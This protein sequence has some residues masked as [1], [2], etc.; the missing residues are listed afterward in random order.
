MTPLLFL[1]PDNPD[2]VR[3]EI[4]SLFEEPQLFRKAS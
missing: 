1:V 3:I 4:R 2:I